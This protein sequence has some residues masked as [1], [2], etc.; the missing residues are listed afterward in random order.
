M[1]KFILAAVAA[2]TIGLS[3]AAT[4]TPAQA[5]LFFGFGSGFHPGYGYGYR[6]RY[7]QPR[8]HYRCWTSQVRRHHRWVQV[9]RCG[10]V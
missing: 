8:S 5:Q 6:H 3:M 7:Y 2:T 4:T 9:R 1:K 10:W